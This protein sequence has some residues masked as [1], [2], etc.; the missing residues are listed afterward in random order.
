M[1]TKNEGIEVKKLRPAV[2]L[3]VSTDDQVTK[4]WLE[5][6]ENAIRDFI[7]SRHDYDWSNLKIYCDNWVSWTLEITKRP[8]LNRLFDDIRFAPNWEPPFDVVVVYKIDRFARDLKVLLEI[9]WKLKDNDISFASTQELI[10]TSTPFGKAMLGILWVFAELDRDMIVQ[11]SQSWIERAMMKGVWRQTKFWYSKGK[12]KKP[13]VHEK[14]AEIVKRAFLL[15]TENQY[16]ISKICDIFTKENIPIPK[17]WDIDHFTQ[18][19]LKDIYKWNDKTLRVILS[20]E[21]YIWK[22]HFNKTKQ[23][24]DKITWKKIVELLPHDDW[25][26]SPVP[27]TPIIDIKTFEKAKELLE[28]KKWNFKVSSEYILWGLIKCDHCKWDKK[29]GMVSWSWISSNGWKYYVCSWKNHQKYPNDPCNTIPL[30]KEEL[31]SIVKQQ[32]KEIILNPAIIKK[33]IDLSKWYLDAQNLI[34]KDITK[35]SKQIDNL[36]KKYTDLEESFT[37]SNIDLSVNEYTK[38][39]NQIIDSLNLKNNEKID[40][41]KRLSKTVDKEKQIKALEYVKQAITSNMDEIFS[42]DDKCK[43]LFNILI[44]N[45]VMYSELDKNIKLTWR[46]KKDWKEQAIP[47]WIII[48]FKLPQE[49]LND[50]FMT[51]SDKNT[52]IGQRKD[53]NL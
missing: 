43:E 7:N 45:I 9:I 44:D 14:Q 40:L 35:V 48:N 11:R 31:E 22:Y 20:D 16:P 26:L 15:F 38:I 19:S 49:F 17:A 37:N 8:E 25:Q 13:I 27:H 21:V 23:T 6:Q 51:E 10:D 5:I 50:V 53:F 39:R 29:R 24:L 42:N 30:P 2:Y 36:M 1:Q 33:H 3:R 47:K 52:A 34:I 41:E 18:K 4:Y 46:K 28:I 12:D 32:M